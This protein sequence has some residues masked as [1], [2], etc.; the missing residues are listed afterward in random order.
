LKQREEL[1]Q[2]KK[3]KEE[4]EVKLKITAG[5]KLTLEKQNAE[6]T[7]RLQ[8]NEK[9]LSTYQQQLR[10]A[11]RMVTDLERSSQ[12]LVSRLE[13]ELMRDKRLLEQQEGL[14]KKFATKTRQF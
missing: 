3:S 13:S 7:K 9:Q 12:A 14:A 4:S 6:L 10:R 2:S 1:H 5:K 11:N 8:S